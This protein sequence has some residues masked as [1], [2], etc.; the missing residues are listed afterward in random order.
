MLHKQRL[1]EQEG[2]G[3]IV[4]HKRDF[5]NIINACYHLEQEESSRDAYRPIDKE[6]LLVQHKQA[7]LAEAYQILEQQAEMTDYDFKKQ[8]FLY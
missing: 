7:R 4:S 6:M 1:E 3:K 2:L 8:L 5:K